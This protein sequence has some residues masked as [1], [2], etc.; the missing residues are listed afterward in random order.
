M[1]RQT[2]RNNEA[3]NQCWMCDAG[4]LNYKFINDP[5]RLTNPTGHGEMLT[6]SEALRQVGEKLRAM[7]PWI[8]KGKMVDKARN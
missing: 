7:M 2:P 1:Y 6:W 8:S 5:R 4:R 3:V